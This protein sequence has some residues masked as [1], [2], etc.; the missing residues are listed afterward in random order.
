[1][2]RFIGIGLC[3]SSLALAGCKTNSNPNAAYF[4]SVELHGNTPGQIA[5]VARAVFEDHDFFVA[6]H[7]YTELIFE[8]QASKMDNLAYGNWIADK[9]VWLR[10]RAQIVPISEAHFRLQCRPFL[11]LDKNEVMEEEIKPNFRAGPYQ[12]LL[13]EVAL[14]LGQVPPGAHGKK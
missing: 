13:D 9:P 10:I 7:T 11:V 2:K 8:K 5:Q 6:R 1:M 14:R 3:I 4:A 12:K